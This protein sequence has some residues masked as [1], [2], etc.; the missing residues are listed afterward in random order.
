MVFTILL[1]YFLCFFFLQ[2]FVPPAFKVSS[3]VNL[4]IWQNTWCVQQPLCTV[5]FCVR[6]F[7]HK[8]T[9]LHVMHMWW[10]PIKG[11]TPQLSQQISLCSVVSSES[12]G[13]FTCT[14]NRWEMEE[15]QK[16]KRK[17]KR[18]MGE[19]VMCAA[20]CCVLP[21]THCVRTSKYLKRE[22]RE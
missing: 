15:E 13:F 20:K 1:N 10:V 4:R 12:L 11:N 22:G 21:H 2:C 18:K 17:R 7:A 3:S 9:C 6:Q 16:R 14:W 5:I 8:S 19:R